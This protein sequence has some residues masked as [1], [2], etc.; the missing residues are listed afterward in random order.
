MKL[1]VGGC[2]YHTT[3]QTLVGV[4]HVQGSMLHGM[5]SGRVDVLAD[6][7]GRF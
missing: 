5:F 2:L 3:V 6:E 1:N 4:T 7:E